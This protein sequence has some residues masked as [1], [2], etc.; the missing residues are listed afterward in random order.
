MAEKKPP[1]EGRAKGGVARA[2]SL[3]ADERKA[4]AKRAAATRWSG[5][6]EVPEAIA[7]SGD[8]PLILG[9]REIDCYVLEDGTR[10]LSQRGFLRAIGRNERVN[11]RDADVPFML[12]GAAFEPYLTPEVLAMAKPIVFTTPNG[13]RAYGF[14]AELLTL[15]CEIYQRAEDDKKLAPNQRPLAVQARILTR[16]L[17]FVGI[18]ALVDEATHY[19]ERRTKDAL[20]EILR[21]FV[22]KEISQWVKTFPDE[23]YTELFRLRGVSYETSS[24]KR[25]PYFGTLTNNIVY[26]RLAPGVKDELKELTPRDDKGRPTQKY[27][28][29]LTQSHGYPKLLSHLGSVVTLMKL[30]TDYNEFK[31]HLDRIHPSFDK[32][33]PMELLNDDGKGL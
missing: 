13:M 12:R 29:R 33:I 27:F 5:A 4:I 16:A 20:A 15:V 19:Q 6:A 7:A 1:V 31:A 8:T 2:Q 21:T 26:D 22:A 18:V 11:M 9:D 30:S 17:A 32:T 28:Q 23:F 3:T 14:R 24:V 25:P 10:V